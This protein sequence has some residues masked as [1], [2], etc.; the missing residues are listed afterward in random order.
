MS[1]PLTFDE[2][3]KDPSHATNIPKQT[4]KNWDSLCKAQ[5]QLKTQHENVWKQIGG[6]FGKVS[7][8]VGKLLYGMLMGIFSPQTWEFLCWFEGLRL[9]AKVLVNTIIK[10]LASGYGVDIAE[11]VAEAGK[12]VVFDTPS[13]LLD[14][15]T[16][17][18]ILSDAVEET[19]GKTWVIRLTEVFSESL[20]IV[21]DALIIIQL[22][23]AVLD[24]WDP[25]GKAYSRMLTGDDLNKISTSFNGEFATKILTNQTVILSSNGTPIQIASWPIEYNMNI[26]ISTDM[27][28]KDAKYWLDRT[29]YYQLNYLNALKINSDGYPI[30]WHQGGSEMQTKSQEFFNSQIFA[31]NDYL[32]DGN[33]IVATWLSKWWPI[34]LIIVIMILVVLFTLK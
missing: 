23:G 4:R 14:T 7:D 11:A 17:L 5:R 27:C 16:T 21:L 2:Y 34:V 28:G 8:E 12:G 32:S 18:T 6:G 13:L 9:S 31:L 30:N 29:S 20:D 1:G 19:V 24:T 33:Q 10:K 25:Q 15:T 3:C 26:K 22:L